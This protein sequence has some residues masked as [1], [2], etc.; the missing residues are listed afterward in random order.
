MPRT[1]EK[2]AE[3]KEASKE[4]ITSAAL[5]LFADKGLA[6]TSTQDIAKAAD[7]SMGLMYSH[8][9]SKEELFT[10]LIEQAAAG[11]HRM[12]DSMDAAENPAEMM[13]GIAAETVADLESGEDFLNM[14]MLITQ[15]LMAGSGAVCEK[16]N[17]ADM[18]AI[19]AAERLIKHGQD[20][21]VFGAGNP[22]EM[23]VFFF[24]NIQGLAMLKC[25]LGEH[26]RTPSA[27]ILTAFL[28]RGLPK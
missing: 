26:F 23:A 12:T 14:M 21:G 10:S 20:I 8:Y 7:V 27:E 24:A 17:E 16:I 13:E 11:L 15:G 1:K 22:R 19:A 28:Y 18:K 25:A 5:K 3:M 9:K 6:A 4:K 2:C